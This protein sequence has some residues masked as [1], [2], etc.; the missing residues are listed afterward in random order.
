MDG[1]LPKRTNI[2][3]TRNPDYQAE[4]VIVSNSLEDALTEASKLDEDIYVIGGAEI[5]KVTEP[6]CHV[7]HITRVHSDFDGDSSFEIQKPEEWKLT[8]SEFH[9][10]DDRHAHSFTIERYERIG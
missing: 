5:Y 4:G 7:M 8:A 2:I 3:I 9:D 6:H 10:V 1:P